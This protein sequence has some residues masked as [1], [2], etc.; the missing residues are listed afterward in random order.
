M[1][2]KIPIV[3]LP[4]V[5]SAGT[6]VQ[7]YVDNKPYLRFDKRPFYHP[8]KTI[9]EF[10][11]LLKVPYYTTI[12]P[13]SRKIVP[14]LNGERYSVVGM[15]DFSAFDDKNAIELFDLSHRDY[16]LGI[17]QKHLD[18]IVR[19]QPELKLEFDSDGR[20]TF[21]LIRINKNQN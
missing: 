4:E 5:N 14:E 16:S 17:N 19:L 6:L 9:K 21:K 18:D 8:G 12:G 10:L 11:D 7:L 3:N 2:K 13:F 1:A 20:S 15:G